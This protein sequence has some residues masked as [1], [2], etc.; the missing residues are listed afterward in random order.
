MA[1]GKLNLVGY[2]YDAIRASIIAYLKNQTTFKDYNFEAS[3]LSILVSLLAQYGTS[4]AFLANMTANESFLDTAVLRNSVVSHAKMLGYTPRSITA[5]TAVI[6][7]LITPDA[8]TVLTHLDHLNTSFLA[9][10]GDSVYPFVPDKDYT[11]TLNDN[12]QYTFG[13]ITLKQ[14]T[15]NTWSWNVDSTNTNQRYFLPNNSIDTSTI[16]VY[17]QRSE[18]DLVTDTYTLVSKLSDVTLDGTSKVFFLQEV[19]DGKFEIVFGDGVLGNRP[20]TGNI[21][22][23]R[24]VKTSGSSANGASSFTLNSSIAGDDTGEITLVSAASGGSSRED[25]ESIRFLAPKIYGSQFRAVTTA[26]YESLILSSYNN[27]LSSVKAWGGEDGDPRLS[28]DVPAY[29][30]VFISLKPKVGYEITQSL[31]DEIETDLLKNRKV[32]T[33]KP[34]FIDPEYLFLELNLQ[35]YYDSTLSFQTPETISSKVLLT[36]Q[37]YVN[38]EL[39]KFNGKFRES[40]LLASVD[41]AD[42]SILNSEVLVVMK[43]YIV[44]NTTAAQSYVIRFGNAIEREP[45]TN[46]PA[47]LSSSDFQYI[48]PA[49]NTTKTC[50][51]EDLNGVVKIVT[52]NS[53]NRQDVVS[54]V[55]TIDYDTGVLV[56]NNFF[57]VSVSGSFLFLKVPAKNKTILPDRNTVLYVNSDDIQI[58]VTND[59]EQ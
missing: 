27:I 53:G 18:T 3:A 45:I 43:K 23:V 40:K 9:T 46:Y 24:Y 44:P 22:I 50:Y 10:Y 1:E 14:G 15:W 25:T 52:L 4:M 55:G 30:N 20:S 48:D 7:L 42:S 36:T 28:D 16:K 31:K 54:N 6:Q 8:G 51:L 35:V 56:L 34:V 32:V 29:G 58:T 13:N 5:S 37:N 57:P 21:V 17:V 47:V 49:D 19:E 11:A 2:D 41:D 26:D 59:S 33:V 39:D 12:G 38:S